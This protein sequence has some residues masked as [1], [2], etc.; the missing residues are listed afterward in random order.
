M[1]DHKTIVPAVAPTTTAATAA[2]TSHRRRPFHGILRRFQRAT[3]GSLALVGIG[4]LAVIAYE[5]RAMKQLRDDN[6]EQQIAN[7]TANTDDDE[8]KKRKKKKRVLVLPFHRMRLVET[9]TTQWSTLA[10]R[11][12]DDADEQI[13]EVE[14]RDLVQVI[15]AAAQDPTICALYA[16][17]GHGFQFRAG[18]WAH[19][20]EVRNA[21]QVW[22][23]SHRRH[24]DPNWNYR[25]QTMGMQQ[26]Q[27]Q[28]RRGGSA[29]PSYAYADSFADPDDKGNKEYLVACAFSHIHMQANGELNLF[30]VASSN[31]FFRQFMEKYGIKAHVFKHGKYKNAPNM[32][33]EKGYTREHR[34]NVQNLVDHID[35][36][37]RNAIVDGRNAGGMFD[38]NVWKMIRKHGTFTGAQSLKLGLVDHLPKLCPLDGL[39]DSNKDGGSPESKAAMMAKW[40]NETDMAR[41]EANERVSLTQYQSLL[42]KRKQDTASKWKTHGRLQTMAETNSA[43][44]ALLGVVG[45]AAPHFNIKQE[46]FS[47][48]KSA[49]EKIAIVSVEGSINDAVARKT[50][51]TLR[52]IKKDKNVKAVILR[53]DSPGGSVT[54]S[55]SILQECNDLPQPVV[56]SMGNVCASGG[57]Y[58]ATGAKRIF[59]LPTTITGSIGVFAIKFD[60]TGLAK[61]YGVSVQHITTG[62]YSAS[63]H[64]F[65][66]LN[67]LVKKNFSHNVDRYYDYFKT[68]VSESR[69]LDMTEVENLAQG[70]VWTG[71]EAKHNGLVDELGGLERAIAYARRTYTNGEAEV[72]RWPKPEGLLARLSKASD[73]VDGSGGALAK[74]TAMVHVLREE[75]SYHNMN[76][77]TTTTIG[78]TPEMS[79][80]DAAKFLIQTLLDDPKKAET[81]QLGGVS[82]TMDESAAMAYLISENA[83]KL[84]QR[85]PLLHPSFWS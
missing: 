51:A 60:F 83:S 54:A 27:Q 26:Q 1:R 76:G 16:T 69:D 67:P 39:L 64:P 4:A 50:V 8:S 36:N 20:E 79:E 9:K 53:V 46:D 40:G 32:F 48:E 11:L 5:Y 33:T 59:A 31:P 37:K 10:S 15:H 62:P 74:M 78:S 80:Y 12:A 17:F 30:G 44:E 52:K 81:M 34:Q 29:K 7:G 43:L 73:M 18:G 68:L 84:Q 72:E 21:L 82:L 38:V 23:E 61:K 49:S 35:T 77:T 66:P 75:M 22:R 47:P 25:D 6:D 14:V 58:I 28:R 56:C 71:G 70:K 41:F 63:S 13:L 24:L 55:E 85:R 3:T 45:Y 19:I 2:T 57:Y 65:Q 42:A